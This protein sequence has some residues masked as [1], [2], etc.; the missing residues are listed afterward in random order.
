MRFLHFADLHLDAPFAWA[1]PETARLRRRN[2]RETLT[3]I[4]RW[5]MRNASTPSCVPATSSSTSASRPTPSPSCG[6]LR[7]DRSPIYL[8]PGNHDWY[9]ARS[10]YALRMEPERPPL[11][12][13]AADAAEL[14]DGLTLWGAAHRAPANTA[15]SSPTSGPIATACTWPW[16]TPPSAAP[17]PFQE[18]ER[19]C[20]PH[21][22]RRRSTAAGM[23]TPS[24]ATTTLPATG[25]ATRY[26]GNPDPLA[27]GESDGRGVVLATSRPRHGH[28]RAPRV[29]AVSQVHDVT[30]AID[31]ARMPPTSRMRS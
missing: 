9:S 21:S 28:A 19:S 18:P 6:E 10:P 5:P 12:R 14:A 23:T 30:V 11:H 17:L 16:P 2:R 29:V 8:A 24:W 22:T 1:R 3:R 31:E 25:T 20:T 15:P 13:G 27:F 7:P 26:P 4:L